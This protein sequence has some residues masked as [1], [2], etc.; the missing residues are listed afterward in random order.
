MSST[1]RG[2]DRHISDYYHTP[3][4]AI[5]DF[6]ANFMSDMQK[7]EALIADMPDKMIWLDPAAGGDK[8]HPEMPY[9]S[10]IK[11]LF[12]ADID[13]LDIR[14]DSSSDGLG[15][16]LTIPKPRYDV[17]IT[18]PPFFLAQEFIQKALSE[19]ND[20]GYVIM[21]LRLNFFGSKKRFDFWQEHMP[22]HTYVHHKRMSFT[23]DGK[24]DSVEYMHCV[25]QKGKNP[26]STKLSII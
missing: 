3:E 23:D 11:D 14:E 13:T 5:R 15:D 21:L 2:Y 26:L 16:Y 17:I 12:G 10:V 20:G 8:D 6:F 4:W 18:N 25:W 7:E 22:T 24:T 1:N 9:P 19:V